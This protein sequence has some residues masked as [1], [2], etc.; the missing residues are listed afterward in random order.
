[1]DSGHEPRITSSVNRRLVISLALALVALSVLPPALARGQEPPVASF[2]ISPASPLSGETVLFSSTSSGPI[3]ML[4]WDLDA[5]GEFDDGSGTTAQRSF[6]TPGRYLVRLRA[7]GP[8]G[9][10]TQ[11]QL[12]DVENRAP[13]AAFTFA[14]SAPL[15]DNVVTFASAAS[16]PDG[17]IAAIAWDLDGDGSFGDA[18]GPVASRQFPAPGSY[19]VAMQVTDS[20]GATAVASQV[21]AIAPRATPPP[22]PPAPPA[23]LQ[24]F[25]IVRLSTKLTDRGAQVRRLEVQAP[26]GSRVSVRCRGRS[27]P[28]RTQVRVVRT[29][30]PL[31]LRAL[32]HRM[33]AGVVLEVR[34]TAP[35]KIGKYTRF[36]LRRRQAPSRVDLC[37]QPGHVDPTPCPL[38]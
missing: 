15:P 31:H 9:E 14:P 12:V 24:P 25:P 1:M 16:D 10:A 32:E 35:Q 19:T 33:R 37:V 13:V 38:A 23:Y 18:T 21:V 8:G 22:A 27:C 4:A 3:T 29:T 11:S 36:R 26:P 6:A 28:V 20:S 5:D 2:S 34:I 30:R 17:S 7:T